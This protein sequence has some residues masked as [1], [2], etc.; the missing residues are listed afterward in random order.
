M[1][2]FLKKHFICSRRKGNVTQHC[3]PDH[4]CNPERFIII[5]LSN[6][7][8]C[9]PWSDYNSM[10]EWRL[11]ASNKNDLN[12]SGDWM[13]LWLLWWHHSVMPSMSISCL[14]GIKFLL[15]L[16]KYGGRL[17]MWNSFSKKSFENILIDWKS[18]EILLCF[19]SV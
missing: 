6:T 13:L 8:E 2:Y 5:L 18:L 10:S 7:A 14:S 11:S 3:V 19:F 15:Q 16:M 17:N 9:F 12:P 1:F 4:Y